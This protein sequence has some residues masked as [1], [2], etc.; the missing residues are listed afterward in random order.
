MARNMTVYQKINDIVVTYLLENV[1]EMAQE[2][3]PRYEEES[4]YWIVPVAC[5]TVR[6][7]FPSGEIHL[8]ERLEIIYATPLEEMVRIVQAQLKR[9]PFIALA[10]EDE[11][12]AKGIKTLQ[13]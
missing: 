5:R 2:G 3:A 9:L 7:I 8:N 13:V 1:G 12:Q 11:L 6:G 10:E 4:R